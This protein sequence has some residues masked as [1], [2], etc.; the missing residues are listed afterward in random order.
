MRR[1]IV[2]LLVSFL[3]M[4]SVSF[5]KDQ[6]NIIASKNPGLDGSSS[7]KPVIKMRMRASVDLTW[8]DT[9]ESKEEDKVDNV[10]MYI[11]EVRLGA[12]GKVGRWTGK[13]DVGLTSGEVS[14]KDV[15]I[16]YSIN[17][18][19][20]FTLG[21][22]IPRFGINGSTS[23]TSKP[24]YQDPVS[25]H[26]FGDRRSPGLSFVHEKDAIYWV[27]IAHTENAV[28]KNTLDKLG[29]MGWGAMTTFDYRFMRE[30]GRF[31][32]AGIA[33]DWSR[34][35]FNKNEK[36]N[37][38]SFTFTDNFPFSTSGYYAYYFMVTDAK[39]KYKFAP[40]LQLGFGKWAFEGQY[41]FQFI[42]REKYNGFVRTDGQ[43]TIDKLGTYFSHGGYGSLRYMIKG[44]AYEFDC[45]SSGI[46]TPGNGEMELVLGYN[47]THM[48][49]E[50]SYNYDPEKNTLT[51]ILGGNLH[52]ISLTWNYYINKHIVWRVRGSWTKIYDRGENIL[53]DVSAISQRTT[54]SLAFYGIQTRLQI[55]F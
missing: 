1:K 17:K 48:N 10:G 22:F 26:E 28:M 38:S 47:Y 19:N 40:E 3:A 12:I 53:S 31:L 23:S 50:K 55:K 2:S 36:Y 18:A 27:V 7:L 52:D 37:H 21:Y 35:T 4:S 39:N 45:A 16:G 54:G 34:P 5:A 30:K 13:V 15:F 33:F 24:T 49:D 9:D 42:Q 8:A 29:S 43:G 25:T 41:Y 44:S 20:Y 32:Q 14:L 6:T 46:E 11:P 51:P